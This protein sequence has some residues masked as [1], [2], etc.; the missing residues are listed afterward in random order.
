MGIISNWI[1]KNTSHNSAIMAENTA[2]TLASGLPTAYTAYTNGAFH[3][4]FRPLIN[5]AI[6]KVFSRYIMIDKLL[7]ASKCSGIRKIMISMGLKIDQRSS[8]FS[9]D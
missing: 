1:G 3:H 9:P 8:M 2:L 4:Y 7:N 6:N 5:E